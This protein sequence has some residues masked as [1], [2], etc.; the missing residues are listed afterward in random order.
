MENSY[1]FFTN[2]ACKYFPCHRGIQEENFNC[3][4]CYCPLYM[5]GTECGGH[6]KYNN[7]VKSCMDCNVPHVPK[8]FDWIN[9]K[10]GEYIRNEKVK[11]EG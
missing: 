11:K 4:F 7:G 8:G 9:K 2:N 5:L 1:R 10:L 6:F 3:L